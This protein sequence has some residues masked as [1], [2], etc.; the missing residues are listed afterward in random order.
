M[1][2]HFFL[3]FCGVSGSFGTITGT[4]TL[5]QSG[6]LGRL[7][8]QGLGTWYL[9]SLSEITGMVQAHG[10]HGGHGGH[11]IFDLEGRAEGRRPH[12]WQVAISEG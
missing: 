6:S 12:G 11:V 8:S 2:L 9:G 3:G 4:H 1:Y 10:G 7:G 5:Q